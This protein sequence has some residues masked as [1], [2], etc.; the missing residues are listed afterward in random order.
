MSLETQIIEIIELI[1]KNEISLVFEKLTNYKIQTPELENLKKEFVFGKFGHDFHERLKTYVGML[2][3][4]KN[5]QIISENKF[6]LT[7]NLKIDVSIKPHWYSPATVSFSGDPVDTR[8]FKESEFTVKI[9]NESEIPCE[10]IKG[11]ITIRNC[12][13]FIPE[14][15]EI[16]HY[17]V[18]EVKNIYFLYFSDNKTLWIDEVITYKMMIRPSN[19]IFLFEVV[20][21]NKE[22]KPYKV[23][24]L[25]DRDK[26]EILEQETSDIK[27]SKGLA[28]FLDLLEKQNEV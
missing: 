20:I 21:G 5:K 13:Q 26:E 23:T 25:Y 9:Y 19:T 28:Y 12:H 8:C 17:R 10:N 3:T 22:I 4:Q 14:T 1:D 16:D 2:R 7:P 24:I 11:K 15:I 18:D 27:N 6:K